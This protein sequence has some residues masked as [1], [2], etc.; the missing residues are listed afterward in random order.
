MKL[1]TYLLTATLAN[2]LKNR[3]KYFLNAPYEEIEIIA[4]SLAFDVDIADTAYIG[5]DRLIELQRRGIIFD[6][7]KDFQNNRVNIKA[8]YFPYLQNIGIW[9]TNTWPSYI[10][11]TVTQRQQAGYWSTG[12]AVITASVWA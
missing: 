12:T 3:W 9:V 10:S 4:K 6:F 2:T 5:D 11:S 7:R 8:N 1:K